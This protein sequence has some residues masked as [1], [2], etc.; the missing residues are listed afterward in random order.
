MNYT[1]AGLEA[2]LID[3]LLFAS[4]FSGIL[5]RGRTFE[6]N[7]LLPYFLHHAA[8]KEVLSLFLSICFI[9]INGA[10]GQCTQL[11]LTSL[12]IDCNGEVLRE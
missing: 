5:S 10:T 6:R 7:K 9:G 3:S 11:K 12:Y 4:I 1:D 2:A 8:S